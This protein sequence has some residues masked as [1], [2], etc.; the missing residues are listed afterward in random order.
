MLWALWCRLLGHNTICYWWCIGFPWSCRGRVSA[1]DQ[2]GAALVLWLHIVLGWEHMGNAVALTACDAYIAVTAFWY[3]LAWRCQGY[4]HYSPNSVWSRNI[5]CVSSIRWVHI[6]VWYPILNGWRVPF[7]R[8]LCQSC[9]Q[10]T[11]TKLALFCASID[12]GCWRICN[13]RGVINVYRAICWQGCLLGA[14]PTLLFTFL[15]KWIHGAHVAS[16]CIV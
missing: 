4:G 15:G 2:R 13:T 12:L 11:W 6:F 16:D 8:I 10:L 1:R 7:W 14:D 9:R 5:D 3:I